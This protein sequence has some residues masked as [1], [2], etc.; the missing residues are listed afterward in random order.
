LKYF[1]HLFDST[2]EALN[3]VFFNGRYA[4]KVI[5]FY[6]KNH[7]KWGK[8]DRNFFAENVYGVVRWWNQLIYLSDAQNLSPLEQ[9][10]RAIAA[11]L[12]IQGHALPEWYEKFFSPES[13]LKK[14]GAI[15]TSHLLH[16]IPEW[17]DS[18]ASSELG[19][20][21]PKTIQALN[22]T[23][24]V[25]LRCNTA[26]TTPQGLQE[27]LHK[28]GIETRLLNP[29]L[30][31]EALELTDRANVFRTKAFELGLFEVQDASSQRVAQL[32]DPKPGERII[33]ACAGAGGKSL[34]IAARMGNKGKIIAMDV[35]ERKLEE[36]KKRAR[37]AQTSLIET[38]LIEGTKTIKRL[39]ASADALL[40]DVPCSGLG[41]LKRNP[42]SK[43]KLTLEKIENL[44]ELQ[45]EILNSYTRMVKPGGRCVYAT[46]SVLPSE[47]QKQV[48]DFLNNHKDWQKV[49]EEIILP[50]DHGYDGFYMAFL[51]RV[52]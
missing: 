15:N 9:C 20:V 30:A 34:H 5:E 32:L 16:A 23:A 47:N 12:V 42:D 31:P 39:E 29:L 43:W 52:E 11:H 25:V 14:R 19:P 37:R 10:H 26:K 1:K 38:R 6:F 4:D 41:V 27:L 22:Q 18:L 13:L 36:L 46:C 35:H 28:E 3:D 44:R 24:P 17:L 49:R 33:D 45:K 2:A 48:D 7:K 51:K 21:W 40:L 50:Q 8:R